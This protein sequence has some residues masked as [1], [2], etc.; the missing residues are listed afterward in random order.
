MDKNPTPSWQQLIDWIEGRLSPVDAA[1]VEQLVAN[2]DERTTAD[3]AWIRAFL[4]AGDQI[5]LDEPPAELR[6]TLRASFDAY[7][8]KKIEAPETDDSPTL[9][10][11][12]VATLTF[13]SGLQPGLAGARG[14][15]LRNMRQLIY[16][17]D[18]LDLSLSVQHGADGAHVEGQILPIKDLTLDAFRVRIQQRAQ[19]VADTSV[20][21]FGLFSFAAIR[22]DTYQ[23]F[24]N[25][26][27]LS[28]WIEPLDLRE[29]GSTIHG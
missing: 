26:E 10:E 12:L 8:G 24:L 28:V 17:T 11:R 19:L 6:N 13:D 27:G 7:A 23:L 14:G 4:R 5:A 25:T 1:R 29:E 2:A 9:L 15:E 22:P 18:T 21:A 20:D 3:V 16:S